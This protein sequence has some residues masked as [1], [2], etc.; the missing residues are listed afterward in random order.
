[1]IFFCFTQSFFDLPN[2]TIRKKS[3]SIILLNQTLK[4]IENIYGDVVGYDM[5]YDEFKHLCR[6]SWE[7][8]YD[9]LCIDKFKERD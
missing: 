8:D 3:K 2:R 6:K 5:T 4:D 9:Y 7:D 1:M